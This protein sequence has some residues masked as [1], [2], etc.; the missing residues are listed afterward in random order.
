M[1]P[2]QLPCSVLL[3]H[4]VSKR[5][6]AAMMKISASKLGTG[7]TWA[8]GTRASMSPIGIAKIKKLLLW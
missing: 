1:F 4:K 2:L 7:M 5:K 3:A 8:Y 6:E